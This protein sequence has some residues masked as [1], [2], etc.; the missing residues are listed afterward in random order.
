MRQEVVVIKK[1]GEEKILRELVKDG[2]LVVVIKAEEEKDYV[3]EVEMRAKKSGV[4]GE[5]RVVGV[6]SNGARLK[7]SKKVPP[8]LYSLPLL[9]VKLLLP[10]SQSLDPVPFPPYSSCL[11]I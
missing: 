1:A 9:H 11:V 7:V 5:I 2:E 4:R 6:V 3:V 10:L 8:H